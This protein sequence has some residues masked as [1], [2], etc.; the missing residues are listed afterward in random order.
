MTAA[1]FGRQRCEWSAGTKLTVEEADGG[2]LLKPAPAFAE[3]RPEDVF[4]ALPT[5][6]SRR[7]V[8]G[9]RLVSSSLPR[10]RDAIS[11]GSEDFDV[12]GAQSIGAGISSRGRRRQGWA[13]PGR[14][15]S[16]APSER[17]MAENITS[18]LTVPVLPY[19]ADLRGGVFFAGAASFGLATLASCGR[20]FWKPLTERD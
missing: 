10:N 2:V 15:R 14:L 5:R 4:G 12:L 16:T 8:T 1:G 11:N 17:G 6:A 18:G 7:P 3:T 9:H 20:P 19:A 13:G